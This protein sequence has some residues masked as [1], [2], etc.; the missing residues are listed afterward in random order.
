MLKLY[1]DNDIYF[2]NYDINC[3]LI[4]YEVSYFIKLI[5]HLTSIDLL[6]RIVQEMSLIINKKYIKQNFINF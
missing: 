4:K 1:I 5:S 6:E 3:L 2:V